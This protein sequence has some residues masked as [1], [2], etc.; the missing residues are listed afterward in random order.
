MKKSREEIK[1]AI[2]SSLAQKPLSIQQIS[3]K[4]SSN[5]ST[6]NEILKELEQEGK[7]KEIISTDKI[8][9]YQRITGDTYYNI[10]ITEEQRELFRYLFSIA[11]EE[12]KLQKERLPNKT[13]LAKAVVDI[14]KKAELNLPIVWYIYGQIP[15]MVS[16][17]SR[18]Y[19]NKF[20]SKDNTKLREIAHQVIKGQTHK[21]TLELKL[22]HYAK[23]NSILYETKEKL[24]LELDSMKEEKQILDLFNE[25]YINCPIN[26]HPEIF[27]LTERLVNVVKKLS[28]L[29]IL[30]DNKI[31]VILALESL[32]KFI[33]AYLLVDSLTKNATYD[34]E[35]IIQ[36]NLGPALETRKYCSEEAISNIESIYLSKLT[37]KETDIPKEA[38]K[39]REIMSDWTGE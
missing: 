3:E 9:C 22:D 27:S 31:K 25:F 36:F 15:L 26:E 5:W 38:I 4:I 23:Y 8:K 32:W 24:F 6:V 29:S 1:Q 20:I 16:D 13:E 39:A 14:S 28:L 37:E 34:K 7:I 19:S 11:I 21:N 12:Y 30:K 10:P 33:A 2:L 17:P 35:E 18:D